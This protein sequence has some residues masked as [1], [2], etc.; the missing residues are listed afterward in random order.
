MGLRIR[1]LREQRGWTQAELAD[2]SGMSR[3][4]LAMIE[5]ET[6]PANTLR[7]NSIAAALGVTTDALFDGPMVDTS[8][9]DLIRRLSPEDRAVLVRMA[10]ALAS[11]PD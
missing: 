11:K 3:S 9:V 6:R 5:A 2:K 1:K 7:L 10:E 4:Q 8:L